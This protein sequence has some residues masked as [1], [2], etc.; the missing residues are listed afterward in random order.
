MNTAGKVVYAIGCGLLT[1][2]IRVW[3]TYPEGVAFAILFM[4]ILCRYINR[5]TERKPFGGVP[6]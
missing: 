1:V 3:G 4:N 5:W 6:Q 2:I